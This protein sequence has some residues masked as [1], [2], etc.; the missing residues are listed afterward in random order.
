A[1]GVED[2]VL[3]AEK[4]RQALLEGLVDLLGAADEAHRGHAVAVLVQRPLRRGAHLRV[5]GEPE[6]VVGAQ[7][8][9]VAAVRVHDPA[10]RPLDHALALVQPLRAQPDEL[11]LQPFDDRLIHGGQVYWRPMS[12]PPTAAG[13]GA[14]R[15]D[16]WLFA[17]RLY[18]S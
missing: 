10:L 1:R 11:A 2:H 16:R 18:R 17:V 3:G 13:G 8:D 12:P 14:A 9:D 5:V 4:A 15:L 6:V 7:V